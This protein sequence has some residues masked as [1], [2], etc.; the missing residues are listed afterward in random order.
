VHHHRSPRYRSK[1]KL[2]T[3]YT[4]ANEDLLKS[5]LH[6][7]SNLGDILAS[8]PINDGPEQWSKVE[9]TAQSLANALRI[10]DP[11]GIGITK[12]R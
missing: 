5:S 7:A 11:K 10:K 12:E 6:T 4:M 3:A 2:A 8:L 9:L 1:F